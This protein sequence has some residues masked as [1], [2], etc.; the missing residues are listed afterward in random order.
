MWDN[1]LLMAANKHPVTFSTDAKLEALQVLAANNF[2]YSETSR[3]LEITRNTLKKWQDKYG[4]NTVITDRQE[5]VL[6]DIALQ[7]LP[8]RIKVLQ[9]VEEASL[10]ALDIAI[11]LLEKETNLDK[12]TNLITAL[13]EI[14]GASPSGDQPN[15]SSSITER[16][17]RIT[18]IKK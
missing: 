11:L 3:Q 9:K 5:A 12:V 8:E 18:T 13:N 10:K 14:V 2:N 4:T 17:E 1:I 6:H 16:I 7:V 15:Q